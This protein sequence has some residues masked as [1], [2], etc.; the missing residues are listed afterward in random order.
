ML[1]PRLSVLPE[2]PF[3]RLRALLDGIEPPGG[4]ENRW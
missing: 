1:N 3:D 4:T 2:Y